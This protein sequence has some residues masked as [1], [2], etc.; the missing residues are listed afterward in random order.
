MTTQQSNLQRPIQLIDSIIEQIGR[1]ER[2]DDA[3]TEC[4]K[5]KAEFDKW[6]KNV[7]LLKQEF[8][9]A[10][11]LYDQYLA[12]CQVK[13]KEYE[14][15]ERQFKALKTEIGAK[16]RQLDGLRAE[17]DRLRTKFFGG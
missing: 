15:D 7:E 10:K 14:M 4:A 12:T 3:E 8:A 11:R 1:V 17:L 16:T 6:A 13:R 5:V 2:L 9:E